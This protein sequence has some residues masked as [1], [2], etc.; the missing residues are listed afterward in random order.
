MFEREGRR[1]DVR[2]DTAVWLEAATHRQNLFGKLF[3][4]IY[5]ED[6]LE[7]Q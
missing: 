2:M 1:I 7:C 6:L 4:I 3:K 5:A